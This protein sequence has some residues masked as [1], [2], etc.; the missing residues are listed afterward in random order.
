MPACVFCGGWSASGFQVRKQ[1]GEGWDREEKK[2]R[3]GV[4][5]G[6]EERQGRGGIGKRTKARVAKLR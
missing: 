5:Y 6:G 2:G 3:G 1:A 4:G